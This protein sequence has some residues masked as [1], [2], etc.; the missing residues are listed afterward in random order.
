MIISESPAERECSLEMDPLEDTATP[1]E[2]QGEPI[3]FREEVHLLTYSVLIR[4]AAIPW[5]AG[6]KFTAR[7][8]GACQEWLASELVI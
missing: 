4:T 8:P 6:I 1:T 5:S 7:A 3:G 2:A